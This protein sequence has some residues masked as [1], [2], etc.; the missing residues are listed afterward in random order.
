MPPGSMCTI[1]S[2]ISYSPKFS[3][4]CLIAQDKFERRKNA[5]NTK[6]ESIISYFIWSSVWKNIYLDG[7]IH[8]LTSGKLIYQDKYRK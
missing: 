2:K 5:Q 3:F 6:V 7:S 4:D 8:S 1:E